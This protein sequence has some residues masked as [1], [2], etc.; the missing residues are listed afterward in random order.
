MADTD[1]PTAPTDGFAEYQAAAATLYGPKTPPKLD[2][3]PPA[4]AEVRNGD[5]AR[6]LYSAQTAFDGREI[7]DYFYDRNGLQPP[8]VAAK[9]VAELKEVF[10][11][12]GASRTDAS[13]FLAEAKGLAKTPP[14]A[15]QSKAMQVDAMRQMRETY[16]PKAYDTLQLAQKFIKRDPRLASFLSTT[17]IGDAPRVVMRMAELALDAKARG[18]I[19]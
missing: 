13:M 5:V 15:E 7:E 12:V 17:G 19:K 4:V 10:A 18:Q 2:A 1:T 11:D 9:N 14:T 3:V 16:G 8:E 6:K